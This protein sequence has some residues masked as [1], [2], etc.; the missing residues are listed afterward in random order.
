LP[1][2]RLDFTVRKAVVNIESQRV[3]SLT[4]EGTG[5]FLICFTDF[6]IRILDHTQSS[7][8]FDATARA[9]I[10]RPLT[11][12]TLRLTRMDWWTWISKTLRLDP[13]FGHPS[14]FPV[15]VDQPT[16]Q[17]LAE[18]R[19]AGKHP[20]FGRNWGAIVC[21]LPDLKIFELVL[22]TWEPKKQQLDT[23]VECAQTWKFPLTMTRAELVWDKTEVANWKREE[24]DE[25]D[26]VEKQLPT[27]VPTSA[28]RNEPEVVT[29]PRD[30]DDED[31]IYDFEDEH[32]DDDQGL[33]SDEIFITE[34]DRLE[35]EH[36]EYEVRV[37]RF[38]RRTVT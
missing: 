30:H 31:G 7:V 6:A 19:R 16:M 4:G 18:Q 5:T 37:V 9:M 10:A 11:R 29:E 38:K 8:A 12:L 14:T 28:H 22:E 21:A 32:D 35:E 2:H 3:L 25:E 36:K 26:F 33:Y 17:E 1:I 24:G 34:A 23:V 20:P 27:H 13:S 15:P